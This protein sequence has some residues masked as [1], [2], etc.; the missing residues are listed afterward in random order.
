MQ[1][2]KK[3]KRRLGDRSDGRLLRSL[4]PM[5]KLMPYIMPQ[6]NDGTNSFRGSAEMEA[7]E[8]YVNEKRAGGLPNY[9]TM[10]Q[11]L[12]AYTRLAS[13]R[14]GLNRFVSGQKIYARNDFEV[15]LCIKK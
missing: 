4:N 5:L 3:R 7:I 1:N 15:M 12:A 8:R 6:R 10:H 11:L 14:P 13:Q 9:T 2:T